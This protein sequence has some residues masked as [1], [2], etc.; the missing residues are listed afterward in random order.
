MNN[1]VQKFDPSTLMRGV[2]DRIKSEFVSLIPDDQWK[3]MIKKEV[4]AFFQ[5]RDSYPNRQRVSDFTILVNTV[6]QEEAKARLHSYLS[7]PEFNTTYDQYGQPIAS[8]AVKKLMVE[9]SGTILMAMFGGI[10]SAH[11]DG[12][13]NSISVNRY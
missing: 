9:N 10:I 5:E 7:S 1:E 3:E 8:E 4:D 2:K 13:R 11:M 6:L 12:L